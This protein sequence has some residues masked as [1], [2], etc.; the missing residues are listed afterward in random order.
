MK[1]G[2]AQD[3]VADYASTVA[4]GTAATGLALLSAGAS[5]LTF[6]GGLAENAAQTVAGELQG[7]IEMPAIEG[8]GN[9]TMSQMTE[10]VFVSCEATEGFSSEAA[11]N[12]T[13]PFAGLARNATAALIDAKTVAE[14]AVGQLKLDKATGI[15]LIAGGVTLATAGAGLQQLSHIN[16]RQNRVIQGLAQ[17][18]AAPR[19]LTIINNIFNRAPNEAVA[20]SAFLD[21]LSGRHLAAFKNL[22]SPNP[23]TRRGGA[24]TLARLPRLNAAL[25][26]SRTPAGGGLSDAQRFWRDQADVAAALAVGNAP[27]AQVNAGGP[28]I[29]PLAGVVVDA[30][31]AL[32]Q[33]GELVD[34]APPAVTQSAFAEQMHGGALSMADQMLMAMSKAALGTSRKAQAAL[35]GAAGAGLG[36]WAGVGGRRLAADN[37]V[38]TAHHTVDQEW[39]PPVNGFVES[40]SDGI[41]NVAGDAAR[42]ATLEAFKHLPSNCSLPSPYTPEKIADWAASDA[43]FFTFNDIWHLPEKATAELSVDKVG[44]SNAANPL[45]V[46]GAAAMVFATIVYG[47]GKLSGRGRRLAAIDDLAGH[48]AQQPQASHQGMAQAMI[49]IFSRTP[50]ARAAFNREMKHP[51]FSA[52]VKEMF[53]VG[54]AHREKS[55]DGLMKVMTDHRSN[56]ALNLSNPPGAAREFWIAR[57][58]QVHGPGTVPAQLRA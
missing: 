21:T 5:Y 2:A 28:A 44:A 31:G 1:A 40:I 54:E 8:A 6:Q 34:A 20:R 47:T 51:Q 11:R 46:A 42:N 25:G 13:R 15:G 7:H 19:M 49:E 29:A 18:A 53:T 14:N 43:K 56:V 36:I 10:A 39:G 41:V 9:G 48:M 38:A 35:Y 23:D 17:D 4:T 26:L 27:P 12:F 22:F 58:E 50:G 55:L 32:A 33:Q 30:S 52:A 45:M 24:A 3:Y 57:Y 37:V 16:T